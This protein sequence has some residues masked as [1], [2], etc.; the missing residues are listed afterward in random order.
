[1][2]LHTVLIV[3][4]TPDNIDVI[5][6]ILMPEYR[7]LAALSGTRA[8]EII[9]QTRPDIILLDIL[10]PHMDGYEVLSQLKG[11]ETTQHT[12]V[13]LL[14]SRA[15]EV[16]GRRGLKQGAALC[17]PKPVDPGLLLKHVKELLAD[18]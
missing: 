15:I 2:K 17:L 4:D 13:I 8:F 16:E 10:M 1:M 18:S 5:A 12:P 14:S 11:N 6:G 7:V 9:N 3:D